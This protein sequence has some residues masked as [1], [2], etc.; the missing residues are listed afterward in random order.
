M[1]YSLLTFYRTVRKFGTKRRVERY[2]ENVPPK[3]QVSSTML[4][5]RNRQRFKL[6]WLHLQRRLTSARSVF[7][8]PAA[9]AC[10]SENMFLRMT[11]IVSVF[12]FVSKLALFHSMCLFLCIDVGM[13]IRLHH[14]VIIGR[15][16][17]YASS[18]FPSQ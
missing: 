13:Y 11:E 6:R 5:Q 3:Q 4:A 15:K 8:Q 16:N 14:S 10:V 12:C 9:A 17:R 7:G 1:I 18:S 2:E